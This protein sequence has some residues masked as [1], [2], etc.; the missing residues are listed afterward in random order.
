MES[1]KILIV[2]DEAQIRDA[3]CELFEEQGYEVRTTEDATRA[4]EHIRQGAFDVVVTDIKMP[5]RSGFELLRFV[6]AQN[7]SM[8]VIVITGHGTISSAIRAMKE[9]ASDYLMKPVRSDELSARVKSCVARRALF[10]EKRRLSKMVTLVDIGRAIS[11]KLDMDELCEKTVDTLVT[12]LKAQQASLMLVEDH[13]LIVRAHRGL[14]SEVTRGMHAPM[15]GSIAGWVIAQKKPVL[16]NG[17]VYD[18]ELR[19][20]MQRKDIASSLSVPLIAQ[21]RVSGVLNVNRLHGAPNFV[22]EDKDFAVV[23]ASQ[24]AS[25]IENARLFAESHE[26]AQELARLN[27]ELRKTY[28]QL[29]QSQ[30]MSSLGLMAGTVAHDINN[31]LSVIMGYAQLLLMRI[32]KGGEDEKPVQAILNQAERIDRMVKSLKGY[33]R[34]SGEERVPTAI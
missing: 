14:S 22:E 30:E 6:K 18:E 2:D 33:A 20:A 7:P 24:V 31:P 15:E 23:L 29:I 32:E 19:K 17:A 21:D 27:E 1:A 25:A 4:M 26:R 11:S 10:R 8:E 16:L 28:D 12:S 9:G 13:H 34:K 5:E 3:L